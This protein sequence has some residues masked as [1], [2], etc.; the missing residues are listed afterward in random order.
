MKIIAIAGKARVGKTTLANIIAKYI[1][2][3]IDNTIPYIE[4]LA[5][6]IKHEAHSRGID[7]SRD[8][9]AYRLFCQS[10]GDRKR[11]E[12]KDYFIDKLSEK[13]LSYCDR[14]ENSTD[15]FVRNA[16]QVV[17]IDDMRFPNELDFFEEAGACR[18]FVYGGD[19]ALEDTDAE[20]RDHASEDMSNTFDDYTRIASRTKDLTANFDFVMPNDEGKD[21]MIPWARQ[22]AE[23]AIALDDDGVN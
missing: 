15:E 9:E 1:V 16:E 4:S 13:L 14:K 12:D 5:G 11:A 10:Y 23:Y 17:I 21:D 2:D 20:W 18:V 6:P 8:P 19:R 22:I 3:N 7:R